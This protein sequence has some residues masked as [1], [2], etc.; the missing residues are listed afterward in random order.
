MAILET[1]LTVPGGGLTSALTSTLQAD[2]SVGDRRTPRIILRLDVLQSGNYTEGT[3]GLATIANQEAAFPTI[4]GI[5]SNT[6]VR[7]AV[8]LTGINGL[9]GLEFT[10]ANGDF[11]S[12]QNALTAFGGT[13]GLW[14]YFVAQFATLADGQ[15]LFAT[16]FNSA[17]TGLFQ[18]S[19]RGN[20]RLRAS[21]RRVASDTIKTL[22]GPT[23]ILV[24]TGVPTQ[25]G[26]AVDFRNGTIL[27]ASNQ[28]YAL[29]N[30]GTFSNG[31]GVVDRAPSASAPTIGR[32]SSLFLNGIIGTLYLGVGVPT[33]EFFE[34]LRLSNRTT[35]NTPQRTVAFDPPASA[36]GYDKFYHAV[37]GV[38]DT[39]IAGT[40]LEGAD[41]DIELRLIDAATREPHVA[42]WGT[43]AAATGGV[44][45]DTASIPAGSWF[46]QARKVGERD[47]DA[48]TD[49]TN[50][51]GVGPRFLMIGQS[52]GMYQ[53]AADRTRFLP[54]PVALPTPSADPIR[55]ARRFSGYGYF[56]PVETMRYDANGP[57]TG[58]PYE[59]PLL[60]NGCGGNG[61]TQMCHQWYEAEGTPLCVLAYNIGGTALS[62]WLE[63]GSSWEN[64]LATIDTADGP[65]WGIDGTLLVSGERDAIL[66]TSKADYLTMLGQVHDQLRTATGNPNTKLWLA[67]TG[68]S[69]VTTDAAMDAIIDA[70]LQYVA[71]DPDARLA[72][73]ARD[74]AL[75]D[76][77]HAVREAYPD[78]FGP[79]IILTMRHDMGLTDATASGPEITGG[80]AAVGG[81]SANVT[82]TH[83]GNA[84]T[85]LDGSGSPT[86]S[87]LTGFTITVDGT[88]RSIV[89]ATLNSGT[90]D[91]TWDG[92]PT[93]SDIDIEYMKG[94]QPDITNVIRDDTTI[95]GSEVGAPLRPTNGK[96]RITAA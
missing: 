64:M 41:A 2:L 43:I 53:W 81:N 28:D 60:P 13:D 9:P 91:L 8:N 42:G 54:Y 23:N 71:D 6:A 25:G 33:A 20:G 63:G 46:R 55:G 22:D 90:I 29:A 27:W 12:I 50:R 3:G 24:P 65:G 95:P 31:Y 78:L 15:G 35:F 86:G 76:A 16:V 4:S 34:G 66:L 80:S 19:V 37:A 45:A 74:A 36:M 10:G 56:A 17:G 26:V 59:G 18:P 79:R 83:P 96:F 7:P 39:P 38:A 69:Q 85:L 48:A 47:V 93:V 61:L 58:E 51:V 1:P 70:T 49:L 75:Y 89:S 11:I 67:V 77:Q 21:I 44:W 30:T 87:G 62:T 5:Q 84:T 68:H 72:Y 92:A 32:Q 94:A 57:G 82:V 52:N 40:I 73:S 88:P 14:L